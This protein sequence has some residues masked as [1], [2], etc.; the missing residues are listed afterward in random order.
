MVAS[1]VWCSVYP[2]V[3]AFCI[4]SLT[5]AE[6]VLA[7]SFLQYCCEQLANAGSNAMGLKFAGLVG[8]SEAVLLP[9]SLTQADLQT[10][11]MLDVAQQ[12][13]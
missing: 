11:G 8:S 3:A 2:G 4:D 9:I 5:I 12:Q 6:H 13:A 1:L 10:L 7:P